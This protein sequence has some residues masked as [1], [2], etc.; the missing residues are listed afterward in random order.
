MDNR[1]DIWHRLQDHQT[2]P[3]PEVFDRLQQVLR[4]AREPATSVEDTPGRLERLQQH[5]LPPPSFA[6]EA[7]KKRI[8]VAQPGRL[9]GFRPFSMFDGMAAACII[10]AVGLT[11]YEVIVLHNHTPAGP[12]QYAIAHT[13]AT[14]ENKPQTTDTTSIGAAGPITPGDS[15]VAATAATD[16]ISLARLSRSGRPFG[17]VINNRALPLVDNDLLVTF[18]SFTYPEIADFVNR[19]EDQALK[20]HLDQ[21]TNIVISKQAVGMIR[22]MYKT[23]S[24]GKPTRKARRMK[25]KLEGWKKTDEKHFDGAAPFNPA[26]PFDL[27]DFIFR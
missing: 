8:G 10:L 27:G 17:L 9:R 14:P 7:V 13:P 11:L 16:S 22:E 3:P 12:G 20:V 25:E 4:S 2:P 5:A 18:T 21:Y 24:N 15:S 19:P 6:R 26:D 23:R 1:P